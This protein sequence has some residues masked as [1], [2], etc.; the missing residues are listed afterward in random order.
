MPLQFRDFLRAHRPRDADNSSQIPEAT[1]FGACIGGSSDHYLEPRKLQ[2]KLTAGS[3]NDH[4]MLI[5]HLTHRHLV[6]F[7]WQVAKGMEFMA[8]RKVLSFRFLFQNQSYKA[9]YAI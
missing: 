7:A 6:Q 8:S 9:L 3:T 4:T 5:K 2:R 1:N